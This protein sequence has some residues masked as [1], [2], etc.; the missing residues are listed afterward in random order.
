[1][2][3]FNPKDHPPALPNLAHGSVSTLNTVRYRTPI[4]IEFNVSSTQ[5]AFNLPKEHCAILKLLVAKDPTMEIVPKNGQP[6]II[7]LL[8][9]PANEEGYNLL[10]DHAIQNNLPT[11]R[12]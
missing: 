4:K 5:T 2:A 3:A 6:H 11:P 8:Q 12:K 1:M 7:D 9:F 10:F